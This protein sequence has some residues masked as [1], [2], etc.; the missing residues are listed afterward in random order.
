MRSVSS[1]S[2]IDVVKTACE[3]RSYCGLRASDVSFGTT[4]SG[5]ML[6]S[7]SYSCVSGGYLLRIESRLP[8][9]SNCFLI[10]LLGDRYPAPRLVTKSSV[11]L[12]WQKH[13]QEDEKTQYVV[14]KR[15]VPASQPSA[16]AGL[17]FEGF[18]YIKF[19]ATPFDGGTSFITKLSFRTFVPDGLLFV[20]FKS[21]WSSYAYLQLLNGNLKFSVKGAEGSSDVTTTVALNDGQFH[22]VQAEKKEQTKNGLVLT[23]DTNPVS[24]NL[25]G[26]LKSINVNVD[27]VYVGGISLDHVVK[28]SGVLSHTEPFIGCMRIDQLDNDKTFDLLSKSNQSYENVR[29]SSNGCPPAVDKG[30]HFRGTGYAELTLSSSSSIQLQISF[31]LRTSWPNGLL[32]AAYSND[33]NSSLFIE[34]RVD[35]LDLR[36]KKGDQSADGPFLVRVRPN[37]ASLCDG[38]WHTINMTIDTTFLAV[39]VDGVSHRTSSEI[40]DVQAYSTKIV[41]NFYLGGMEHKGASPTMDEIAL[42][43]GVNVTSYGGCLADL[44]VNGQLIDFPKVRSASLNVSFAG[45]PDFTWNGPTCQD[46]IVRVGT[47]GKSEETLTDTSG[48]E[49]FSGWSIFMVVLFYVYT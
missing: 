14:E 49:A 29:W 32:L 7:V 18:G 34:S 8:R 2:A 47:K 43:Y 5:K 20:A 30:M 1:S 3:Y 38:A 42:G 48:V 36:Y 23:V 12:E 45:C 16:I 15:Y 39:T 41:E 21:D 24:Q 40:T 4:C 37:D 10:G 19:D 26:Q 11:Q 6:L 9:G 13:G 44:E 33:K 25:Q 35:G 31:R 22:T 28:A 46:Q 27:S 17:F